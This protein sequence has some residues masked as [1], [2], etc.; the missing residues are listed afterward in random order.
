MH[1][2]PSS[3]GRLYL[4]AALS[5]WCGAWLVFALHQYA[6]LRRCSFVAGPWFPCEPRE[7]VGPL[8]LALLPIAAMA[9]AAMT[10]GMVRLV[11]RPRGGEPLAR[12]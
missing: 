3:Y 4:A 1:V 7:W 12:S 11:R 9:C 10:R 2:R 6:L 5:L 8:V